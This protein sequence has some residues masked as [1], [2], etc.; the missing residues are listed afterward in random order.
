MDQVDHVD[1]DELIDKHPGAACACF[2]L[3]KAARA[4]TQLFDASYRD[5]GLKTT[6]LSV[7]NALHELGTATINQLASILMVDRTT[8]SRNLGPLEKNKLIIIE[9]GA[10]QRT[11]RSSL[12][13]QGVS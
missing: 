6:Q 10:D 7:L 13:R 4:I 8:L 2:N 9:S 3:R 1:I 5:L 11:G 12:L